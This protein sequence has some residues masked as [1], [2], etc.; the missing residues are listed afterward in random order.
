MADLYIGQRKRQRRGGL[1]S[2]IILLLVLLFCS[3]Y[4]AS[5][6]IDYSWW[7]E[8]GQVDT[9][10]NLLLYGTGPIVLAF[11]VFLAAFW[12]AFKVGIRHSHNEGPIFGVFK[13]TFVF[14]IALVAFAVLAIV[15]AN[16]TVDSWTV[17]RYFG[18]LRLPT[19]AAEFVDP[20]F[21]KP[22]HF[23]FFGL[24]FYNLLLRVVLVGA[25]LSLLI[26][27]LAAHAENLSRRMPNLQSASTV[28]FRSVF[29]S[30]SVRFEFCAAGCGDSAGGHCDQALFQP[31]RFFAS[32]ITART[33]WGWTG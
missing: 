28:R 1:L 5:T 29:G 13:R 27:W 4:I 26:Y 8:M 31:V 23:Y 21:G 14:R 2:L 24:P 15:V 7:S 19:P 33:W 9:W 16:A 12:I 30:R 20:I 3:R 18:G 22:L 6:L 17:V 25:V 32:R 10:V 11:L